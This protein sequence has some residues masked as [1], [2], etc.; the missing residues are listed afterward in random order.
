MS[1]SLF[2]FSYPNNEIKYQWVFLNYNQTNPCFARKIKFASYLI[3]MLINFVFRECIR[4]E[5]MFRY[6]QGALNEKVTNINY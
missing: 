1:T 5:E 2:F 6:R 3:T 4:T